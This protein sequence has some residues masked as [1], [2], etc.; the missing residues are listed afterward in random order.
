MATMA[1]DVTDVAR[2]L[3]A[4]D[5]D[6]FKNE[7]NADL[8]PNDETPNQRARHAAL[9]S[10][11][12][13]DRWFTVLTQMAKSV[14]GQLAAKT[15]DYEADK[16]GI[17]AKILKEKDPRRVNALRAQLEETKAKYARARAGTLRFKCGLDEALIEARA[18][19]DSTRDRLYDTVVADERNRYAARIL[20]LTNAID[21][22]RHAC[23]IADITPEDHDERLWAIIES[24]PEPEDDDEW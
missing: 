24:P 2:S 15:E 17:R 3:M 23:D 14:D 4:L 1:A 7:V 6:A 16:A 13:V 22:H 10:P 11:M 12:L 8:R 18:L 9:R 19:R 5:Y 21:E 20:V